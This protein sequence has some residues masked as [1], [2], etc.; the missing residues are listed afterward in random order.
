VSRAFVKTATPRERLDA[1]VDGLAALRATQAV[2]VPATLGIDERGL[3]LERL[4]LRPLDARSAAALGTALAALHR[5]A[6]GP[7]GW[8]RDNFI[9]ATP[10]SNATSASWVAFFREQRLVPQLARAERNG[11]IGTLHDTGARLVESLE[12]ILGDHAPAPSLLHGDLWGGNAGGLPDGT[13]VVFDPAVYVG[14]R[15]ADIA[16][17]ELFGGFPPAFYAAYR[18]AWPLDDGY[19]LRRELYNLYH[20]L[21]HLN[22]FGGAYLG[23]CRQVMDWLLAAGR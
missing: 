11:H 8:Q 4:D 1:E 14:D 12:A 15:E 5:R 3:A 7:F 13:P 20:L 6:A 22:L 9:G 2:R 23:R 16:M 10:Q 17:T 21:N 19:P 18:E